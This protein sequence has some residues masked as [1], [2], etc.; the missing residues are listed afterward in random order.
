MLVVVRAAQKAQDVTKKSR[1]KA[2]TETDPAPRCSNNRLVLRA[3]DEDGSYLCLNPAVS[4]TAA[5]GRR[6]VSDSLYETLICGAGV[7]D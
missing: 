5:T 4:E 1:D 6:T 7:A 3:W 2:V